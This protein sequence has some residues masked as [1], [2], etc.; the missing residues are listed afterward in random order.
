MFDC[1]VDDYLQNIISPYLPEFHWK[2][3]NCPHDNSD[4]YISLV[5]HH[6]VNCMPLPI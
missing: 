1:E 6:Q 2:N 4:I 3:P 5:A